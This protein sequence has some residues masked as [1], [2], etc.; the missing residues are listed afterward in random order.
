MHREVSKTSRRISNRPIPL[1]PQDQDFGWVAKWQ[2]AKVGI[3]STLISKQ[4]F[5]KVQSY[6]V[7]RDVVCQLPPEARHP[8]YIAARLKKPAYGMNDV[9][10]R[11]WVTLDKAL[12]CYGMVPTRAD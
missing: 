10:R 5:F 9:P 3:F 8:T 1:L 12:R 7:N 6:D 2:P 4:P 11:W